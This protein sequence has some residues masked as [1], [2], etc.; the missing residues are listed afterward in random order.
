[1]PQ[2]E[3]DSPKHSAVQTQHRRELDSHAAQVDW[4]ITTASCSPSGMV[5]IAHRACCISIQPSFPSS[6]WSCYPL[7]V[8]LSLSLAPLHF[9]DLYHR[10]L[11][12][13]N[14]HHSLLRWVILKTS[15]E[16]RSSWI[17]LTSLL[18]LSSLENM[19]AFLMR[20]ITSSSTSYSWCDA[21]C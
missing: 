20:S 18:Q 13:L 5:C 10:Q 14:S 17:S 1:M 6:T 15:L 7:S 12:F 11:K 3:F 8:G 4:G 9:S 19:N 16:V 2:L 21:I